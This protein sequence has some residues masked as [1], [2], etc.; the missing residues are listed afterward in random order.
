MSKQ[1]SSEPRLINAS[2]TD[3]PQVI[4]P[5]TGYSSG[6]YMV[7]GRLMKSA[8]HH[9]PDER[10]NYELSMVDKHGNNFIDY[11]SEYVYHF[12]AHAKEAAQMVMLSLHDLAPSRAS[13]FTEAIALIEARLSI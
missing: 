1:I 2:L 11:E 12:A 3:E 10:Y 13:D 8:R 5:V 9:S 6:S 4:Y 7:K